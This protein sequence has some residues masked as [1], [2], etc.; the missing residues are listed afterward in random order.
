MSTTRTNLMP[1][2]KK[3]ALIGKKQAAM[4]GPTSAAYKKIVAAKKEAAASTSSGGSGKKRAKAARAFSTLKSRQSIVERVKQAI[5][6]DVLKI[7]DALISLALAGNFTAARALF[8]FAGVYSLPMPDDGDAPAPAVALA[9]PAPQPV[10][11]AAPLSPVDAFFRRLGIQPPC[12][13]P[14]PDMAAAPAL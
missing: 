1:F 14:D 3:S 2:S 11:E 7:N 13:E 10:P 4:P 5:W 8:D 9:A 6:A 12:D